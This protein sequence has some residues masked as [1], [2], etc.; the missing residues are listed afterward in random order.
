MSERRKKVGRAVQPE[1]VQR[2]DHTAGTRSADHLRFLAEAEML[3]VDPDQCLDMDDSDADGFEVIPD[4]DAAVLTG[5]RV[6][7]EDNPVENLAGLSAVRGLKPSSRASGR[8]QCSVLETS[9][10]AETVVRRKGMRI[11]LYL[12]PDRFDLQ[13]ATKE[14]THD[15]QTPSVLSDA[16]AQTGCLVSRRWSRLEFVLRSDEPGATSVQAD[17]DWSGDAMKCKSTSAGAGGESSDRSVEC[18][19][20]GGV[21]QLGRK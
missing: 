5:P 2:V 6:P 19:S 14:I 18:D 7:L 16:E 4:R 20:T 10:A 11:A 9:T 17:V 1:T 12:E 13:F 21:V 8:G 15:V 3:A